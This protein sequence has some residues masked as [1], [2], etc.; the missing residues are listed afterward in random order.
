MVTLENVKT[1]MMN[2]SAE[3][4]KTIQ[5]FAY[6]MRQFEA[7]KKKM[8]FTIGESV[9]VSGNKSGEWVGTIHKISKKNVVVKNHDTKVMWT[10]HPN[11][12]HKIG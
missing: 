10:C 11:L 8:M 1:F 5:N 7:Q 2:A 4:L 12:V 6:E 9:R 3:D